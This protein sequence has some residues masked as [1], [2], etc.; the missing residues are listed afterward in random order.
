M[1]TRLDPLI[2]EHD[3]A[4]EAAAYNEWLIAKL[5]R[6]MANWD[7]PLTEHEAV[8]DEIDAMIEAEPEEDRD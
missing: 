1:G 5:K 4:E 7:G 2:Y 3:T 6:A 8:F